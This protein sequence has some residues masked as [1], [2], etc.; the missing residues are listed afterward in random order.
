MNTQVRN[1][2]ISA[3]NDATDIL[4]DC[5]VPWSATVC[6]MVNIASSHSD[7]VGRGETAWPLKRDR[8]WISV[9][10]RALMFGVLLVSSG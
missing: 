10:E 8:V 7:S 5:I 2:S 6:R 3:M 4:R 1:M 9:E